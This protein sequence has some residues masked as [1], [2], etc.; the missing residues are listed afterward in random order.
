MLLG[1]SRDVSAQLTLRGAV[2]RIANAMYRALYEDSAGYAHAS[3]AHE[4]EKSREIFIRYRVIL[5]A[6]RSRVIAFR[7]TA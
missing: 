5:E 7:D 2:Y 3:P 6:E 1:N 4:P